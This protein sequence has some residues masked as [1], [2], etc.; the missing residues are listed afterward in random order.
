MS[1]RKRPR[2]ESSGC[3]PTKREVNKRTVDKWLAEYDRELNTSVWLRYELADRDRVVAL[4]CAVCTRFRTKLE[5]MRNYNPAFIDGTSNVRTSTFKE[6]ARTE[7]HNRAMCLF[8][9]AQSN[10]VL[11]YAPIAR[12][13]TNLPMDDRSKQQVKRKFEV[14]YVIAR[15]KLAFTKMKALCSLEERHGVDL[16]PGYRNDHACATFV[17]YISRDLQQK[18]LGA[19]GHSRFFSIQADSS[20]DTANAE[21]EL[22]LVLYFDPHSA[23]GRVYVRDRY[24][25]VRELSSGTATGLMECLERAFQH[26][27]ITDW[28]QKLIGLGCDGCSANMGAR[29][30]RGLLQQRLPWVIVFWCLIHRLELSLKDAL[31]NTFFSSVDEF[32]MQVYYVYE[33]SPKKCRELQDVVEE[34]KACLEPAELP[35]NGGN[36]PLRACGTRFVAHKV[37]ALGRV[38]DR[39]G[40]YLAHLVA[41]TD[42]RSVPPSS[43]QKLKGY[44]TRWRDSKVILGCG[45]FHDLLQPVAH[46]SK[47]LQQDQLC[48][49]RAIDALMKTKKNLDKLKAT[50][51]EELPTVKKVLS[52]LTENAGSMTYQGQDLTR[53]EEGITYLK[54]HQAQYFEGV[55]DCIESRVKTGETEILSHATTILATHGW[56]RSTN[57]DF[58]HTALNAI[59][60]R[61]A[62]P[63]ERSGV[64]TSL[65]KGEWD[66]MVEYGREY[67]NLVQDDYTVVWWK[68][69]NC[70]DANKWGNVLAIVE[71]LFCVP[72]ANGHL[73]RVFSQ[74]KLIK[75]NRRNSIKEDTLDH[76]VRINVEGPSLSD[77]D[78]TDAMQLWWRDK[79]RRVNQHDSASSSASAGAST[80]ATPE[81]EPQQDVFDWEEWE[82]LIN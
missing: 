72:V 8:K 45:F 75:T 14:S 52:R 20:T 43:R 42:D 40:A 19:L 49:V 80:S 56:N 34:L 81:R 24:F 18:L 77:W 59:C 17:E 73:E 71:L 12:A 78:P 38:I 32:L 58:G 55:N 54:S 63:L 15:E 76:L 31:K 36:R 28:D 33:K 67:I 27:N 25:T 46:L 53:H 37:A 16:G 6:H 82:Q 23:D 66:D 48:V 35:S 44:I 11:D 2:G 60:C 7:I 30:L 62:T 65:V 64:D 10:S 1:G 70:V 9:K 21:N 68:L 79:A 61:F 74:L 39:F 3:P 47:V 51:F 69:F 29:G 41:L 22:F 13:L 26:M 4:K 57:A 50:P 5:S